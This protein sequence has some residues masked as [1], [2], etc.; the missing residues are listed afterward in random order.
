MYSVLNSYH[1]CSPR[2]EKLAEASLNRTLD[3]IDAIVSGKFNSY[4]DSKD[5]SIMN[6]M[7][8]LTVGTDADFERARPPN[9]EDVPKRT[10]ALLWWRVTRVSS[11]GGSN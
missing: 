11:A 8:I 4:N 6:L 1:V 10:L 2:W 7:S 5:T 3:S 9:V